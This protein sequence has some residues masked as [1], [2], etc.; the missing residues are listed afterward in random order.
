MP[1]TGIFN[2]PKVP[3]LLIINFIRTRIHTAVD[4]ILL[5]IAVTIDALRNNQWVKINK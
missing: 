4:A 2:K 1:H 5:R 3:D